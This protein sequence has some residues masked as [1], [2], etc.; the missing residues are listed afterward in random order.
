MNDKSLGYTEMD[1]PLP[2][3]GGKQAPK[4]PLPQSDPPDN[5]GGRSYLPADPPD[6]ESE[7]ESESRDERA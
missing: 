4:E 6:A 7:S 5:S 2:K 3:R 1:G